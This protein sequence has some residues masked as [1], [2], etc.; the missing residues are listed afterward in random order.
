MTEKYIK[1]WGKRVVLNGE[2]GDMM[3]NQ[4]LPHTWGLAFPHANKV[5]LLTSL[6][7]FRCL[8]AL[9]L[10]IFIV[11]IVC[12]IFSNSLQSIFHDI[13]TNINNDKVQNLH[14]FVR[15]YSER[16]LDKNAYSI[17]V[18]M[19]ILYWHSEYISFLLNKWNHTITIVVYKKEMVG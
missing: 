16:C 17:M 11:Y 6:S 12:S 7:I 13:I 9:Y 5:R 14:L 1:G 15:Y 8:H 4:H 19:L 2:M 18:F 3:L 10:T